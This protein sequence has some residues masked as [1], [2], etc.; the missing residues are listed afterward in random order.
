[1]NQQTLAMPND[2]FPLNGVPST[3]GFPAHDFRFNFNVFAA[4]RQALRSRGQAI[5]VMG[6]ADFMH[7]V[8]LHMPEVSSRIDEDDF[9]I[10]HL[11][12][13]AMK[14]ATRDAIVRYEFHTV[15]RHFS[16]IAYLFEHA[17]NALYDAILVSY[18][19]GLF[20]GETSPEYE[21]ARSL[22]PNNLEEALK[23]AELRFKLF[24]LQIIKY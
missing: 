19:E 22:L 7:H 16:F 2:H 10:L 21:N 9:G 17:E 24:A 1:M 20:I 23:K 6:R 13:G 15:R 11:E 18:L 12:V 3:Q 8:T 5:P 14:L 4:M